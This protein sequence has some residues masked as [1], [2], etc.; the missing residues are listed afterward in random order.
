MSR[1]SA[2]RL[3]GGAVRLGV[4]MATGRPLPFAITFILTHRCN[5]RC[6]H[7]NVPDAARDE[8]SADEF[9]RAIDELAGAGMARAS[10]SGGEALLRDDALAIVRHARARGL[11]TSLNSNG[12]LAAD[13]L[14]ELAATLDM[15]VLSLDGPEEI[16]D[17]IRGRRGSFARV[18]RALD[19]A[20]ERG[21]PT[22]TITVLSSANLHAVDD[23]L[24]LA[25]RHGAW[26]YFQPAYN[27]CFGHAAGLDPALVYAD[28]AAGL[29]DARAAG[30]PVGASSG[31][32][33][34]L[35]R[36]P[37]FSDCARCTA[38]RRFATVMPDGR[39]V[40]CHLVSTE[41][42]WPD[43]RAVGFHRAFA[44]LG[45]R[46]PGPG[47]AI[48]PYQESDLIFGL[49]RGAVVAAVRRLAGPPRV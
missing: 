31:Y 33:A 6:A 19:G 24:R 14:D 43:G 46:A 5:L 28:L 42:T 26:A 47:C 20:R 12:W 45:R 38:G 2:L 3:V 10:F 13:R 29:G 1:R 36:G 11:H 18:I 44:A 32:L 22:A 7:C 34:R 23:V 9:C 48:S 8:M 35:G 41:R 17:R 30:R 4:A 37:R 16:H 49:D 27:D 40:P 15:L 25:E 21:L 39:V